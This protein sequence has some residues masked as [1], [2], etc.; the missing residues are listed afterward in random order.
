MSGLE[1]ADQADNVS[2]KHRNNPTYALRRLKRDR[3]DLA[4]KVG[5]GALSANAAAIE[6]PSVSARCFWPDRP[7]LSALQ[8]ARAEIG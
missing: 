2:L 4:A 1:P 6:A 3:P 5:A 8:T 7:E